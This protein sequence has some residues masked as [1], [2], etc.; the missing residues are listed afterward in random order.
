[1]AFIIKPLL[2][3]IVEK[4]ESKVILQLLE[5]NSS[6]SSTTTLIHNILFTIFTRSL[7][8]CSKQNKISL[9]FPHHS[10]TTRYILIHTIKKL[11]FA[12]NSLPN[13]KTFPLEKFLHHKT[14]FLSPVYL[15]F[16][17]L[18]RCQTRWKESAL[19]WK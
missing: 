8:K 17:P 19:T 2:Y 14:F 4:K 7:I 5:A 11:D 9:N 6:T 15:F 16:L 10:H 3:F 1:M 18:A 12:V 13:W